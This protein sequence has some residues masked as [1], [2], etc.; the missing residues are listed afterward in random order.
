MLVTRTTFMNSLRSVRN[1]PHEYP[2]RPGSRLRTLVLCGCALLAQASCREASGPGDTASE[3]TILSAASPTAITSTVGSYV[4]DL[5]TVIAQDASGNPTAGVVVTFA[6]KSGA[7][8]VTGAIATSNS[9]GIARVS[10]WKLGLLPGMNV[11]TATAGSLNPVTFRATA[12]AGPP[13]R[14]QKVAGDNQVA[15]PGATLPIAPEVRVIDAFGNALLGITVEFAVRDGGG[16]LSKTTATTDSSGIAV[17]GKWTLGS[18]LDQV[19]LV[20]AGALSPALFHAVAVQPLLP[21]ARNDELVEGRVSHS[22]LGARSCPGADGRYFDAYLA[23][24]KNAGAYTFTFSSGDFDTYLD[25]RNANGT[26]I[27]YNDNISASVSNSSL[28]VFLQP[29]SLAVVATSTS[30]AA[31]GAYS[32]LYTGTYPDVA[33]CEPTFIVRGVTTRQDVEPGDCDISADTREDRYRIWLQGG[34]PLDIRLEDESYSDQS[35]VVENDSGDIL[36]QSKDAG[37][38]EYKLLFTPPAS[39]FYSVKVRGSLYEEISYTLSLR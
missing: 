21:C 35:F 18:L 26:P 38:Y 2:W 20:S 30:A 24:V 7:G 17:A 32:L 25:L 27:A 36:G 22:E 31:G 13:D 14:I 39:G 11:V 10:G 23:T 19:V 5:P 3:A 34:E 37:A 16:S 1:R 15:A 4:V 29:G 28:K 9:A 12:V 33:G 6:V 8:S